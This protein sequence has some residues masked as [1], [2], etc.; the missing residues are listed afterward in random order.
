MTFQED[1]IKNRVPFTCEQCRHYKTGCHQSA[2]HYSN[3]EEEKRCFDFYPINM[4]TY[5]DEVVA[6]L[7]ENTIPAKTE[8]LP[9]MLTVTNSQ[10]YDDK[11]EPLYSYYVGMINDS[12]KL[13]R[14]GKSAYVFSFTHIKEILRFEPDIKVAYINGSFELR[15]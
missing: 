7:R 8:Y 1:L 15:K 5:I 14:K 3:V 2:Y 10:F 12:L 6:D 13:I 11:I 9:K 4:S